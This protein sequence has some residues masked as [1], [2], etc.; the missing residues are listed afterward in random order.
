[1]FEFNFHVAHIWCDEQKIIFLYGYYLRIL[2]LLQ[3][4]L[5]ANLP[6]MTTQNKYRSRWV[7][8]EI[9]GYGNSSGADM[10]PVSEDAFF[11]KFP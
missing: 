11:S 4:G 3:P 2:F 9:L 5:P 7:T 6:T 8:G 10:V 1:M